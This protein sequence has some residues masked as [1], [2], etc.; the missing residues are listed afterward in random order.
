V[1]AS[2]Q[3]R[4]FL[5]FVF[6]NADGFVT[7]WRLPQKDH[8]G[9]SVDDLEAAADLAVK[10][11]EQSD[12]YFCVGTRTSDTLPTRGAAADVVWLPG[13]WADVDA[14]APYRRAGAKKNYAPSKQA[15]IDQ[16]G[17]VGLPPSVLWDSGGGVQ[18]I[19]RV[20]GGIKIRSD[21]DRA[22][23]QAL[24]RRWDRTV[25]AAMTPHDA[26][27]VFDLARV[28]RVPGTRNRWTRSNG[29]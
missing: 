26:D 17:R 9:F 13:V 18:A 15:A 5:G 27:S 28:L 19:W 25:K 6:E 11:S 20:E 24:T 10:W 3:A 14:A 7:I 12:V 4:D 21:E 22:R 1:P 29:T 23:A 2:Q 16:L 8:R